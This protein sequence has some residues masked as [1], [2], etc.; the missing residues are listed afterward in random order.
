[1]KKLFTIE[2]VILVRISPPYL[3]LYGIQVETFNLGYS[4]ALYFFVIELKYYLDI[5]IVCNSVSIY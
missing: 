5:N 3:D 4:L 2:F 1:M